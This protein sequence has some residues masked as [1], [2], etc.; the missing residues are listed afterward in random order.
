M[1]G[2]I[3]D[4]H[5]AIAGRVQDAPGEAPYATVEIDAYGPGSADEAP[6]R[7][8]TR[9]AGSTTT[10]RD[11]SYEIQ[12]LAAGEYI[13]EVHCRGRATILSGRIALA[14]GARVAGQDFHLSPGCAIE[15]KVRDAQGEPVRTSRFA[16]RHAGDGWSVPLPSLSTKYPSHEDGYYCLDG[17]A[18]GD[19]VLVVEAEGFQSVER[20]VRV[21]LR[22]R[23][24]VD[25]VLIPAK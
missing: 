24:T 19:Y 22:E 10:L 9:H 2:V 12:G 15:G 23:P 1:R 14:V 5:G 13:L 4:A 6:E 16:L 7:I 17:L 20:R 3:L 18:E 25:I 8:V 21:E 11:G